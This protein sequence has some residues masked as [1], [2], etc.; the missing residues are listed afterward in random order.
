MAIRKLDA[1]LA[2]AIGSVQPTAA[3]ALINAGANPDIFVYVT[4]TNE[5]DEGWRAFSMPASQLPEVGLVAKAGDIV[6]TAAIYALT[7]FG[8]STGKELPNQFFDNVASGAWNEQAARKWL[9]ANEKIETAGPD[10][11]SVATELVVRGHK[12]LCSIVEPA[13]RHSLQ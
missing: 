12:A 6:M 5:G 1:S 11:L 7:Q 4:S 9:L 10:M 8:E 13:S 2:E 3:L